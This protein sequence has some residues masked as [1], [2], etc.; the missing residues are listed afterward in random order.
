MPP[1]VEEIRAMIYGHL[2]TAVGESPLLPHWKRQLTSQSPP[3][4]Y[5]PW[6]PIQAPNPHGSPSF[7]TVNP[8]KGDQA[9]F[10]KL[11]F[12]TRLKLAGASYSL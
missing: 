6:L 10:M 9:D 1:I 3:L 7:I 12:S 11:I 8:Y 4:G 5:P 2:Q